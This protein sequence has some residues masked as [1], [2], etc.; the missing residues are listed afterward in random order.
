MTLMLIL[1]CIL[2][3]VVV[4]GLL[5]TPLLR[6]RASPAGKAGPDILVYESQLREVA[7]DRARGILDHA[8]AREASLEIRRRILAADGRGQHGETGPQTPEGPAWPLA[9]AV[10]LFVPVLALGVYLLVGRPDLP[11]RPLAVAR[12]EQAAGEAG[13]AADGVSPAMIEGMVA[14]LAARLADHPEDTEGWLR[15]ARSYTVLG[16]REEALAIYDQLLAQYGEQVPLLLLKARALREFAGGMPTSESM[17]LMGRVLALDPN[18]IEALW[19]SALTALQAGNRAEAEALF[20]K[21]RAALPDGSQE[22][23]MLDEMIDR[24]LAAGKSGMSGNR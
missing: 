8:A 14:R 16:R 10:A 17:A 19:F 12:A 2:L 20:G 5:V 7:R 9:L 13:A 23:A 4:A 15:L 21:A 24:A 22:R 18:N 6:R 1:A 11:D 3:S